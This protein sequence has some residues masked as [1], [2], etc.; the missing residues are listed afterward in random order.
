[1][2]C[3]ATAY[4]RAT[5]TISYDWFMTFENRPNLSAFNSFANCHILPIIIQF[6]NTIYNAFYNSSGE[7]KTK[8]ENRK[9]NS[10]D[11]I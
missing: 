7:Y 6:T 9:S 2:I 1:M 4:C 5:N 10:P 11:P 3:C 8:T